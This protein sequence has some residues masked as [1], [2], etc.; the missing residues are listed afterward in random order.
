METQDP[1]SAQEN[2][3]LDSVH[4]TEAEDPP[5]K[6][7]VPGVEKIQAAAGAKVVEEV[8]GID[9]EEQAEPKQ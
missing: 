2:S 3:G 5:T 9:Q 7:G 8:D 1:P 4:P 6:A